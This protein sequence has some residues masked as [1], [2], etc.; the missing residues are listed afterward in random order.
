LT[1]ST[2]ADTRG[3]FKTGPKDRTTLVVGGKKKEK[4]EISKKKQLP[5]QNTRSHGVRKGEA[6]NEN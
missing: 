2:M 3:V 6:A 1:T 4:S 5:E